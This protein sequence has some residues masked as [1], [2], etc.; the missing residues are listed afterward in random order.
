MRWLDFFSSQFVLHSQFAHECIPIVGC[1]LG[2]RCGAVHALAGGFNFDIA[3]FVFISHSRRTLGRGFVSYGLHSVRTLRTL[4]FA[5]LFA[6]PR[7]VSR[8]SP[9]TLRFASLYSPQFHVISVSLSTLYIVIR[10]SG[11]DRAPYQQVVVTGLALVGV[12]TCSNS[13][14]RK[15]KKKKH[16]DAQRVSGDV[17]F[18]VCLLQC[19]S[20]I[21]TL[22]G[23]Q[24]LDGA[25]RW[26]GARDARRG[27][28]SL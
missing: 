22:V 6:V 27:Q 14:C 24:S 12:R 23:A 9:R 25:S 4:R 26:C 2:Y 11:E 15:T 28:R 5:V 8:S 19:H 16:Q 17:Q 10:A 18:I 20:R 1:Q 7:N 21:I 13:F 3:K